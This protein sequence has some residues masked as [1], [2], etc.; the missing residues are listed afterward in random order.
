MSIGMK[1]DVRNQID[2]R[3]N[4][5]K[6]IKIHFISALHGSNVGGLYASINQAYKSATIKVPT[7]TLNEIL[8]KAIFEHQPPTVNGR[9]IKLRYAHLGGTNP[10]TVIIHGNQTE[11]V[12][13]AYRR[14]L[15]RFFIDKLD[16][17]GT[18][19]RLEFRTSNNPYKGKKN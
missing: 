13:E 10:P 4:F 14:Y 8:K 16:L 3:L 5:I 19:V 9:R 17:S 6:Y 12:P 11:E 15:R 18:P 1:E 2:R 7:S